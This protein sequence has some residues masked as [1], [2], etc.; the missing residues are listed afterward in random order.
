M[1]GCSC[2]KEGKKAAQDGK[3]KKAELRNGSA[4][5]AGEGFSI[6]AAP[7][8]PG[9]PAMWPHPFPAAS[10]CVSDFHTSIYE[11]QGPSQGP[12]WGCLVN[13]TCV[14]LRAR[15]M[16]ATRSSGPWGHLPPPA[17]GET[18]GRQFRSLGS[19]SLSCLCAIIPPAK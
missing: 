15:T 13:P 18:S 7:P 14:E 6:P 10:A 11:A 1:Q 2:N 16:L 17:Y 3:K 4:G 9:L 12:A 8:S 19:Y 5:G